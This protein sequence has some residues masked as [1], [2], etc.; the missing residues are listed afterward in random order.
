[1]Y[2]FISEKTANSYKKHINDRLGTNKH[3]PAF[4]LHCLTVPDKS[5][6]LHILLGLR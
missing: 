4:Q 3:Q 1:M 6:L 2:C 5:A